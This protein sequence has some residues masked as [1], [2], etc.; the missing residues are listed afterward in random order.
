MSRRWGLVLTL[1]LGCTV[2]EG[3][4]EE[5]VFECDPSAHNPGCGTDRDGVPM[6]CFPGKQLDGTNFCAPSCPD[7][8][9]SLVEEHAVC[10][11]GGAKLRFCNPEVPNACGH[12][13]LGCLRTDVTLSGAEAE[14]VCVTMAPCSTDA[15]CTDPVR[16][17]CATT[18]LNQLYGR[19]EGLAADHLYC[20]QRDCQRSGSA[21]APGQSCLPELVT[22]AAHPPD[23]CVPN[24]D[25]QGDCPP[26]HFCFRKLS[27]PG[28]PPICLPGL[29]G[30]LCESD[31]DCLVGRCLS[32]EEPDESIRLDL[33]TVECDSQDDCERFDSDQGRF[34]CLNGR[35]ATPE[36]Y[37]GTRCFTDADCTRDPGTVCVFSSPPT[38]PSD[39]GT[40]SRPC[41]EYDRCPTRGG[42]GQVCLTNVVSRDGEL[43]HTCYPGYFGLPCAADEDCVGGMICRGAA[44]G[45][46]RCTLLC[47][48]T[49]GDRDCRSSRWTTPGA[50]CVDSLCVREAPMSELGGM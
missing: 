44:G 14:G 30:F 47:Q 9:M 17:T 7:V 4:F 31:V 12:P 35:C 8:P 26:N 43:R 22:A 48:E 32:D 3:A 1:T 50:T 19:H 40:C 15:E 42:F 37:R 20:L 21:C 33:C 29:L 16:S 39:E 45:T 10:V 18:F 36:A 25:A 49:A 27:G 46:P 6:T 11:D 38:R 41:D 23:I 5:R 2:D 24:C 34:V 13:D 28:S